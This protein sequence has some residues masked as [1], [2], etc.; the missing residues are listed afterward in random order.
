MAPPGI[1]GNGR[2]VRDPKFVHQKWPDKIFR[3]VNFVFSLYSHFGLEGGGGPPGGL[4]PSSMRAPG[5]SQGRQQSDRDPVLR[6]GAHTPRA[7]LR[8]DVSPSQ[9]PSCLCRNGH[10]GTT[11][12]TNATRTCRRLPVL[13]ICRFN[14]DRL[15][16]PPPFAFSSMASSTHSKSNYRFLTIVLVVENMRR[17]LFQEMP[18]Q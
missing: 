8:I 14:Y 11:R 6:R 7:G 18:H 17:E 16:P 2:G 1:R 15:A 5:P 13:A 4:P 12:C 3:I 9:I 10:P